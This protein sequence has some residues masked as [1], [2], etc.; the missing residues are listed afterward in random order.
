[1]IPLLNWNLLEIIKCLAH[2]AGLSEKHALVKLSV[3]TGFAQKFSAHFTKQNGL[4]EDTN[5][6]LWQ[7]RSYRRFL[8]S[9]EKR[10]FFYGKN[11][12]IAYIEFDHLKQI[13]SETALFSYG[14][15]A[16]L[17]PMKNE[18]LKIQRARL[19]CVKNDKLNII[20]LITSMSVDDEDA[21]R[22]RE[23]F[24]E[25]PRNNRDFFE[26]KRNISQ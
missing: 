20:Q 7:A 13:V 12:L 22:E 17:Q 1:M 18:E 14:S 21:V 23:L 4:A 8:Y 11:A 25:T 9:T 3:I 24:P 10:F 5:Y 2:I 6:A 26:N 19:D 16:I 15:K